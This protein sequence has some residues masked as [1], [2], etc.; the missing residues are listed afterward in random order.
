LRVR[1][2]NLSAR[3]ERSGPFREIAVKDPRSVVQP[4]R[5]SGSVPPL[6]TFHRFRSNDLIHPPARGECG[7]ARAPEGSD[8][9]PWFQCGA[10][11]ARRDSG[12]AEQWES[13]SPLLIAPCH[14]GRRRSTVV[15]VLRV[16]SQT[17]GCQSAVPSASPRSAPTLSWCS[18]IRAPPMVKRER[19]T[20]LMAQVGR[21]EPLRSGGGG[22]CAMARLLGTRTLH[23]CLLRRAIRNRTRPSCWTSLRTSRRSTA[24]F[25]RPAGS[26]ASRACC[27]R[28]R[29]TIAHPSLSRPGARTS[30]RRAG[31]RRRAVGVRCGDGWVR[32]C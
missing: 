5:P 24:A 16:S 8:V 4:E 1:R 12:C 23:L 32:S 6:S 22:R 18:C 25:G 3:T 28:R 7:T 17:I 27:A 20:W 19:P 10:P 26:L 11:A 30:S 2:S 13:R 29:S 21:V 15:H 14:A 31:L 9:R